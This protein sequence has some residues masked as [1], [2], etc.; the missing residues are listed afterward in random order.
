MCNFILWAYL[1]FPSHLFQH[2]PL[3]LVFQFV[4]ACFRWPWS[5]STWKS[6]SQC[7]KSK[8]DQVGVWLSSLLLSDKECNIADWLISFCPVCLSALVGQ[9]LEGVTWSEVWCSVSRWQRYGNTCTLEFNA[10]TITDK[11]YYIQYSVL[12]HRLDS[13][14]LDEEGITILAQGF[15]HLTSLRRLR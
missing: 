11:M 9:Q 2:F 13:L 12:N 5:C 14:I 6:T 4:P 8:V 15:S 7:A 1:P 3:P 10:F